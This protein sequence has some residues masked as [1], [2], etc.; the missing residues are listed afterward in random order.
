MNRTILD[1]GRSERLADQVFENED[2]RLAVTDRLAQS[3]QAAI[4]G[5]IEVPPELIQQAADLALDDPAVQRLVRDGLVATHRNAL[6]GNSE[7]VTIDATA[8]GTA[9]RSAL[10]SLSPELETSLPE[11]PPVEVTLPTGRLSI[12]GSIRNLVEKTTT[13]CAALALVGGVGSLLLTTNRPAILRRVSYWAFGASAFWL[14]VAYGVPWVARTLSPSSDAIIAAIVDVF[15]GAMIP[16]AITLA[17]VGAALFGASFVWSA[18]ATRDPAPRQSRQS[19]QHEEIRYADDAGGRRMSERRTS[20]GISSNIRPPREEPQQSIPQQSQPI[21]PHAQQ[22][23]A[24]DPWTATNPEPPPVE[25]PPKRWVDG[26][27]Y[28]DVE[29]PNSPPQQ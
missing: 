29:D 11:I 7:P 22:P 25:R 23:V 24:H 21:Q 14:V 15:F 19:E 18:A 28:V 9:A 8:L 2:L 12:L 6:E 16:P 4:P 10:V 27:G 13:I 17:V 3:L 5:E 1:P 20:P 26:V